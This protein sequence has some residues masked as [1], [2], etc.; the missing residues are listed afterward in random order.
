MPIT[1]FEL[2]LIL[3]RKLMA[4]AR[5]TGPTD[6]LAL[7]ISV[8][9]TAAGFATYLALTESSPLGTTKASTITLLLTLDLILLLLLGALIARRIVRIWIGRRRGL[10]GSRFYVRL[11]A[12]FSLLAVAPAI[13]VATFSA[14]FFNLGVQ[15]WF[16]ERVGTAINESLEVARAYLHEHQQNIRADALAMANDL[17]QEAP[18]LVGD[19]ERFNQIVSTQAALR[20]LSEAL[21]FNAAT[22]EV[23]ARTALSYALEFEPIPA[24]AL[25]KAREGEVALLISGN[26]DRVR[27]LARLDRLADTY[28]F[29][30]RFVEARVLAHMSATQT[31]VQEYAELEGNRSSLQITVTLIFVVVALLLLMAAVWSGLNFASYLATPISALIAAAE[32]I[33]AGD[34]SARVTEKTGPEDEL[35]TLSRAFNRMTS[36]LESQRRDLIEA[37]RQL[38]NRRR[39]TEA[40]LAGVSAGVLGLDQEGVI[41][42]PNLPAAHLLGMSLHQNLIG[43]PL[44]T[45]A[46]EMAGLLDAIRRRPGRLVESQVQLKRPG[47]PTRTL[48]VR[49]SA[50]A[51]ESESRGFVITFDD[52]TELLSAQRKAAWADVA[53]R[54]AHEIKNPLTPIQLSAERLRRKYLKE[55]TSDPETFQLCTD[56]IVRHVVDIGRMVDEFSAFARM[57]SPVMKPANINDIVR[58]SVFLQTTAHP[59]IKVSLNLPATPLT[60][61]CDSRQ[62][63]Q[64]L[65]NILKN[66][67]EAIEGRA[68]TPD[69]S[70]L[71]PGQIDVRIII[72]EDQISIV[73][74]DN[75][76]GLPTT[77]ERHRL[78]EP[79]VTTRA[80]GTGL[81]LAIVK[82]IMEDHG[83]DLTIDD[84]PEGGARVVLTIPK[85]QAPQNAAPTSDSLSSSS[86]ATA[87][88]TTS[89]TASN[90]LLGAVDAQ[91]KQISHGA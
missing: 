18:R 78:T 57:P 86:P 40:V 22:G 41:T 43:Q 11:V 87:A 72:A 24:E 61:P 10:A 20:T 60:I 8:A 89:S 39:F 52:I 90:L 58:Q 1:P 33:R 69:G 9:A 34:L 36:Q 46:P 81:G 62:I 38:D 88:P 91:T 54:I 80:K 45:A 63:S 71:T 35:E 74:D 37:N 70:P 55:I 42:L 65:T 23:L 44:E 30:G 56:T 6:T 25:T 5:R 79:Y 2:P 49:L 28:L 21:V 75:G 29:V 82:K 76:K 32:R 53:R 47:H 3:W 59:T 14:L 4:W 77:E 13:I 50:E 85:E 67:A 7:A 48:L 68:R 31:A 12:V 17:N 51:S 66:A 83:G 84:R 73:A 19:S 15:S 16:N 27:A 64:A 26:D